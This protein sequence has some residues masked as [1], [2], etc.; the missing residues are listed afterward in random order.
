MK[1]TEIT[2]TIHVTNL[3]NPCNNFDKKRQTSQ[4]TKFIKYWLQNRHIARTNSPKWQRYLFKPT[5]TL[6]ILPEFLN[7]KLS[8]HQICQ[9]FIFSQ[10]S[11]IYFHLTKFEFPN[12]WYMIY[13]IR[14]E[15]VG[16]R[17][18]SGAVATPIPYKES[19]HPIKQSYIFDEIVSLST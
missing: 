10:H 16:H 5:T 2:L 8:T 15:K 1:H 17:T 4:K 13:I 12:I 14:W 7:G 3:A 11:N 6:K 18:I 9:V 19:I